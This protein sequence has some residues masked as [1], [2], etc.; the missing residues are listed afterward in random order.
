MSTSLTVMRDGQMVATIK[1]QFS[2][3]NAPSVWVLE[4]VRGKRHQYTTMSAAQSS[5][6][7]MWSGCSFKSSTAPRYK[8]RF[9]VSFGNAY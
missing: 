2:T 9:G 8:K 7:R 5:A 6:K 3:P 1:K 4:S